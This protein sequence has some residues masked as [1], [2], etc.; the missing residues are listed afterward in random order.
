MTFAICWSTFNR[1]SRAYL[2]L[3]S[4]H[5]FRVGCADAPPAPAGC[6]HSPLWG[7]SGASCWPRYR[8]PDQH[9]VGRGC[10][11]TGAINL[12]DTMQPGIDC[13]QACGPQA[14]GPPPSIK[15]RQIVSD[16]KRPF[17]SWVGTGDVPPPPRNMRRVLSAAA[18]LAEESRSVVPG[19]HS[20]RR[21]R[22]HGSG[23]RVGRVR[24]LTVAVRIAEWAR[25]GI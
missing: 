25:I 21:N 19:R 8:S 13:L 18:P 23:S 11:R 4:V 17:R 22:R 3:R 5:G 15:I 12:N 1:P 16:R 24:S 20:D 7:E 10:A 14:I 9:L 6:M 2:W